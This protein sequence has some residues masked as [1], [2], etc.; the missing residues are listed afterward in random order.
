MFNNKLKDLV[1]QLSNKGHKLIDSQKSDIES[2][3][4]PISRIA[5]SACEYVSGG[6]DCTDC[7]YL[8][9]RKSI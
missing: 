8:E 9:F 6:N 2:T 1:Q 3:N 4:K 7:V 5:K